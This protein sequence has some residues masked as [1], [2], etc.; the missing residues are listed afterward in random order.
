MYL[1]SS[2]P[3]VLNDT[4]RLYS[5]V[6]GADVVQDGCFT[7]WFHMYGSTTGEWLFTWLAAWRPAERSLPKS[8]NSCGGVKSIWLC[9]WKKSWW[10]HRLFARPSV[11]PPK[12]WHVHFI[13]PFFLKSA[14]RPH[15][16]DG[17]CDIRWTLSGS[18]CR[19]GGG[20]HWTQA[21]QVS[22]DQTTSELFPPEGHVIRTEGSSCSSVKEPK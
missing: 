3:R 6:Y 22:N 13:D 8:P 16:L 11:K 17:G 4:A 15:P 20:W 10:M 9:C 19:L 21:T 12:L 5:P 1:E 2:S 14:F 18:L 7:F